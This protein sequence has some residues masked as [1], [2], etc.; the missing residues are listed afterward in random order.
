MGDS[1]AR[2]F[3]RRVVVAL[4]YIERF[5]QSRHPYRRV[6]D[7]R[8]SGKLGASYS[9]LKV[10]GIFIVEVWCRKV[11][12]IYETGGLLNCSYSLSFEFCQNLV[13]RSFL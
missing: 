7:L 8:F 13:R 2:D 10:I 5:G 4:Q 1:R 11:P 12:S 9:L 6:R 3:G